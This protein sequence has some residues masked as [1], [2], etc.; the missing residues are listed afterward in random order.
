MI[1]YCKGG[2]TR[3]FATM[4]G[5]VRL[6]SYA[7]DVSFP[8]PTIVIGLRVAA[9]R[10]RRHICATPHSESVAQACDRM[11]LRVMGLHLPAASV[12]VLLVLLRELLRC[13]A[14]SGALASCQ[15]KLG[16]LFFR[17]G[18]TGQGPAG[19]VGSWSSR[20]VLQVHGRQCSLPGARSQVPDQV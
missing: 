8:C 15:R 16:P 9:R 14:C 19:S 13:R 2:R 11:G 1:E 12:Q 5:L 10:C 7:N 18:L 20:L 6:S 17:A 3:G 4:D